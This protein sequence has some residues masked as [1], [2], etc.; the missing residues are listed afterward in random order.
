M[1]LIILA[2]NL[3]PEMG[4]LARYTYGLALQRHGER[5]I[6]IASDCSGAPAFDANSP[7]PIS[8]VA[9]GKWPQVAGELSRTALDYIRKQR[10]SEPVSAVLAMWWRPSGLGAWLVRRRTGLPYVVMAH[11][12]EA[13]YAGTNIL[14]WA[15]QHLIIRGAAGGL[16][17]SHYAASC[18]RRRGLPEDRIAVIYG[19]VNPEAFAP[20]EEEVDQPRVELPANGKPALLTVSRL[21]ATKGHSQTIAALPRVVEQLGQVSYLIVGTGPEEQHLRD[22]A[23]CHGV[24]EFVHFVGEVN[25]RQLAGLYHAA[26]I[27]IMTSL[28]QGGKCWEGFGLVYLEASVCGLPVIGSNAGGIP[29]AIVDGETGLLVNPENPE[30]IARAIV[31]LASD[32]TLAARMGKAG[33]E[34]ALREFTWDRVATRF[35]KALG[36]WNLTSQLRTEYSEGRQACR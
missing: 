21:V 29:D 10:L 31:R 18:L 25:D 8:R 27:F 7:V 6:V 36:R 2:N 13:G 20:G 1:S 34:R 11:D 5:L 3:L 17:V 26:D 30:E 32:K 15:G 14:K 28:D 12:R 33:R 9:P 23:E 19:G 24:S 16:A 22:V 4:G 35:Y